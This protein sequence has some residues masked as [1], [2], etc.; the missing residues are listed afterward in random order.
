M[1]NAVK[2]LQLYSVSMNSIILQITYNTNDSQINAVKNLEFYSV[3]M[4]T[5]SYKGLTGTG[6]NSTAVI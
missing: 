4:K 3:S 5:L 6:M 1:M 2:N